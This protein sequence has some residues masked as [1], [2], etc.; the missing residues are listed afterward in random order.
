MAP[1]PCVRYGSRGVVM[2]FAKWLAAST[3]LRWRLAAA[4][5]VMT[6]TGAGGAQPVP[7]LDVHWVAPATCPG[8]E[9]LEARVRRLLGAEPPAPGR[10]DLLVVD[11]TVVRMS[12]RY[13]LSLNVRKRG[14]IAGA[15]RAFESESCESLAGAA[16]VTLAL[17]ARDKPR[18][19][20][21]TSLQS[22]PSAS[23]QGPGAAP[24]AS[25]SSTAASAPSP[26]PAPTEA[27][28]LGKNGLA[29]R[30]WSAVL[31]GPLLVVDEGVLPSWSFGLGLAAGVRVNRF[32]ALWTGVLWLQQS[33]PGVNSGA[34]AG[35]YVRRSGELSSCYA[36]PLGR[37]ELGP[38]LTVALEDVTA[39]GT[40][41]N[42][43]GRPGHIAWMTVGLAARARWSPLRWTALFVR[44]RLAFNTSRPT[45]T[46]DAVGTLYQT[47]IAA[48]GIDLGSEWIL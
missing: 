13:R 27:H 30:R 43:V 23:S 44:P 20:E 29:E 24:A 48:V 26:T 5:A 15:T 12:G 35:S 8:A 2:I 33:A 42:V 36:W 6:W 45:F 19:D 21:A 41:P 17:L 4:S 25:G 16:A 3:S 46:I 11:G 18:S 22:A 37:L 9:D 28:P 34:Y 10:K 14:E 47:P 1:P 40:G 7:G 31:G 38:C 32:E 39:N